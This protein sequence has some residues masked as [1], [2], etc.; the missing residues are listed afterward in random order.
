MNGGVELTEQ[1]Y[2]DQFWAG[3]K[4]PAEVE[5]TADDLMTYEILNIFDKFLSTDASKSVLEIGGA[6][7]RFL[8]YLTKKFKCKAHALVKSCNVVPLA[9]CRR[10]RCECR[11]SCQ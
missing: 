4:L 3:C 9:V 10:N 5:K 8:V 1:A 6:P 7:G 11:Q 2:W